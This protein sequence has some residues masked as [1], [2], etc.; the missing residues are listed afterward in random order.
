[1]GIVAKL[2]G[3]TPWSARVPLDPLVANR[4][5]HI[6]TEQADEASAAD[7]APKPEVMAGVAF[8]C[9]PSLSW[10]RL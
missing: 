3:R 2:V 10:V 5:N 1:M 4:F 9:L 7:A 6:Q 8:C